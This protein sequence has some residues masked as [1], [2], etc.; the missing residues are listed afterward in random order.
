MPVE[1]D[2]GEAAKG[3]IGAVGAIIG[4]AGT[5]LAA[6]WKRRETVESRIEKW[7]LSFEESLRRENAELRERV[8]VLESQRNERQLEIENMRIVLRMVVLELHRIDPQSLILAQVRTMLTL[9]FPI[10]DLPADMRAM[11]HEIEIRE[12][13]G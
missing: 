9:A 5:L 8:A 6:K 11:L 1:V 7:R 12:R 10:E 2:G 13:Q 4:A 3:L